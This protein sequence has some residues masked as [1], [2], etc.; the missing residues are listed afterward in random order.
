M[1]VY[2]GGAPIANAARIAAAASTNS[3][4]VKGTPGQV[5]GI[6]LYNNAAYAVFLKLYDKAT[7]PTVGTDVPKLT[8]GVPATATGGS[9]QIDLSGLG[10]T[11]GIGYGITKLIADN[12]TTVVVAND[13]Q[14]SL[15]FQ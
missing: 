15:Q 3:T 2:P 6:T 11:L 13:L 9:V 1:P 10:F 8:I 14:G 7:A 4:L 5:Y 12:D